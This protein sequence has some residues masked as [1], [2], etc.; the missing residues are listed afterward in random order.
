MDYTQIER[1]KVFRNRTSL[2][3]FRVDSPGTLDAMM[4][5]LMENIPSEIPSWFKFTK[6]Y[7]L[8][9]FNNAYYIT[10]LIL[11]DK[12]PALNFDLYISIAKSDVKRVNKYNEVVYDYL[13]L[14]SMTTAMVVNYLRACEPDKYTEHNSLI[15]KLIEHYNDRHFTFY[16]PAHS[17]PLLFFGNILHP[18]TIKGLTIERELFY[19]KMPLE[20]TS[21]EAQIKELNDRIDELNKEI[22]FLKTDIPNVDVGNKSQRAY[23]A[24]LLIESLK[25]IRT[26]DRKQWAVIMSAITGASPKTCIN[27]FS[28]SPN[29]E[30]IENKDEINKAF[31]ALDLNIDI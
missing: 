30:G 21:A 6:D 7:A 19:P 10:I 9:C 22:N 12:H 24:R 4:L 18:D 2:E 8:K 1:E 14:E 28:D 27:M 25:T 17:A 31:R 23:I 11:N 29:M 5:R 20:E 16:P 3:E 15:K 13:F 26:G